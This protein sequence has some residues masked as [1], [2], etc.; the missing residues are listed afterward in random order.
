MSKRSSTL[1]VHYPCLIAEKYISLLLLFSKKYN[2]LN[3]GVLY[4]AV[5]SKD[6]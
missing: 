1:K 4:V 2:A 6:C 3:S 5:V